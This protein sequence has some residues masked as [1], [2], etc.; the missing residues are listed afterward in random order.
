MSCT[1]QTSE[2]FVDSSNLGIMKNFERSRY[3]LRLKFVIEK[4]LT[5]PLFYEVCC[6]IVGE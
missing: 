3:T 1:G 5:F 2:Y 6:E 4:G